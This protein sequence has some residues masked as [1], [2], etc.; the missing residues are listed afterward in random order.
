MNLDEEE[1]APHIP[2]NLATEDKWI[3]SQFN[4]LVK[5]VTNSLENYELGIAVQ[6]LYD[7]IWDV[8]CDWYIEICKSR[9]NGDDEAAKNT[10]RSVLV[11]VFTNTLALLHPFMPFITEEIWQAL[12]ER[13]EGESVMVAQLSSV[14][15][16]DQQLIKEFEV[17]KQI[18]AGVRQIRLERN[19]A[20]K[21]SLMLN[22]T[23]GSHNGEFNAVIS[24]MCNLS[25]IVTATK[26]A[27]SAV[28]MVGTTEY[29]VPLLSKINIE[30]EIAK[31][32]E[33]IAYFEKFLEGV[34]KK[35][36]NERFVANAKPEVVELERKKKSDA[37]S[38]IKT[39]QESIN[40]LLLQ[41]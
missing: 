25:E 10:A 8:F 14:E 1:P 30:E 35:L 13:K 3:L 18:V 12:K 23:Q 29:A 15:N 34:M 19:I 5:A 4:T 41:K 40:N 31:A 36:S 11:Y 17:A 32:K 9:L 24:K 33:K 7:F 28:F 16:F 6:N 38:K 21:E 27:T 22:I 2:E 39:L 26:D 20:N 37:E